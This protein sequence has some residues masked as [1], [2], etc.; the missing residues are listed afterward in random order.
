MVVTVVVR[1]TVVSVSV[2]LTYEKGSAEN[3]LG[4]GRV[5]CP[6]AIPPVQRLH[7][8]MTVLANPYTWHKESCKEQS[9]TKIPV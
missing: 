5:P 9:S 8:P 7:W 3:D 2:C 1:V 4:Y 6:F